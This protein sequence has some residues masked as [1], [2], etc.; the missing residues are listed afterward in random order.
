MT[1]PTRS[2]IFE[3]DGKLDLSDFKPKPAPDP[4]APSSQ[5]VRAVAERANFRSREAST[6]TD[7]AAAP[8]PQQ[9]RHRT[10]R[11]VQLNIKATGETVAAFNRLTQDNR[12]VAG[13]TLQRALAALR[14]EL[15]EGRG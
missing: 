11:N 9:R 3:D 14:R 2:S 13:E 10:G 4:T 12:W 7:A 5:E 1:S 6:R 8:R 15:G